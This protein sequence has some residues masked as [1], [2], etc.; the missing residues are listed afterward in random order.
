MNCDFGKVSVIAGPKYR[1]LL[2]IVGEK[3]PTLVDSLQKLRYT[4]TL[5]YFLLKNRTA[6]NVFLTISKS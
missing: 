4:A 2:T 5:Y 1:F 6:L 3:D